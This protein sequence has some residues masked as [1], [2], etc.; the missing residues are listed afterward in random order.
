MSTGKLPLP[1][2]LV[3]ERKFRD[4]KEK[5]TC[6][7]ANTFLISRIILFRTKDKLLAVIFRGRKLKPVTNRDGNLPK[8][9]GTNQ[10]RN[11]LLTVKTNPGLMVRF[12]IGDSGT[13]KP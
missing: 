13:R 7:K 9:K 3:K 8:R 12:F 4:S 10:P 5:T 6:V 11:S 2:I 1:T